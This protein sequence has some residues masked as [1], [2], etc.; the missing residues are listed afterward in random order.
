[1]P[2]GPSVRALEAC[3]ESVVGMGLR[4]VDPLA[5]FPPHSGV[6]AGARLCVRQIP[7]ADNFHCSGSN[8]LS[9]LLVDFPCGVRARRSVGQQAE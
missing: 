2:A 6:L 1:M 5:E 7:G 8:L 4:E 9:H 3:V